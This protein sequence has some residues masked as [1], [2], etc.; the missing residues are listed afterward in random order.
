M[1]AA[2]AACGPEGRQISSAAF[3]SGKRIMALMFSIA[4]LQV[5]SDVYTLL[6]LVADSGHRTVWAAWALAL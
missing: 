5:A 4:A 1:S 3:R 2:D 6:R